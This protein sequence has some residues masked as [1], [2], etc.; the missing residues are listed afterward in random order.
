MAAVL[1]MVVSLATL[2]AGIWSGDATVFGIGLAG[3]ELATIAAISEA[4]QDD[5][6]DNE[7]E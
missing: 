7:R 1:G 3:G 6:D 2:V 4:R 5:G